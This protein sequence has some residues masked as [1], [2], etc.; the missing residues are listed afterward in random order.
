M[1]IA[2][3]ILFAA[4]LSD[5][6][7]LNWNQ[8]LKF[9]NQQI[10]HLPI[11]LLPFIFPSTIILF[12][13]NTISSPFLSTHPHNLSPPTEQPTLITWYIQDGH[14]IVT[15]LQNSLRAV[16]YTHLDVYKRQVCKR[17]S[18]SLTTSQLI[19]EMNLRELTVKTLRA[20]IYQPNLQYPIYMLTACRWV[21][22]EKELYFDIKFIFI[23][24]QEPHSFSTEMN[25]VVF[26]TQ[27]QKRHFRHCL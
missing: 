4:A 12:I 20:Y 2:I 16:S 13:I 25:Q 19:W 21:G 27:K 1:I 22:P 7:E 11:L 17:S 5:W 23:R 6:L 14:S 24:I 8:C 15:M 18:T 10:C 26:A 3:S 9:S